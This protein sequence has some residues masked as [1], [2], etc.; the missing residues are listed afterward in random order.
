MYAIILV[1]LPDRRE[2]DT[3]KDIKE[4]FINSYLSSIKKNVIIDN[5]TFAERRKNITFLR[6]NF[7]V[8]EDIKEIVLGLSPNDC[9]KGPEDDHDGYKGYVLVFKSKHNTLGSI[10]YI[11]IRYN[12][13]NEVV[14]ISFHG[15]E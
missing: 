12:P 9:I 7:L 13:P 5:Y 2:G 8:Q 1:D 4:K 10:I 15:D 11:K 14:F 3:I 6:E